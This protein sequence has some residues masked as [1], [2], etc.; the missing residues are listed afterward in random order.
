[1]PILLSWKLPSTPLVPSKNETFLPHQASLLPIWKSHL[2]LRNSPSSES[3]S[4][5]SE[6]ISLASQKN[7]S[8]RPVPDSFSSHRK[9]AVPTDSPLSSESETDGNEQVDRSKKAHPT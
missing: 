8:S 3:S 1:M 2:Q 6:E 4:S 5:P 7:P 9:S